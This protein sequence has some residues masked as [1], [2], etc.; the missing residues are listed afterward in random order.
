MSNRP[1]KVPKRSTGNTAPAAATRIGIKPLSNRM[2][3]RKY[4]TVKIPVWPN[5]T[6]TK[7]KG[8][9][10]AEKNYNKL[11]GKYRDTNSNSNSNNSNNNSNN[12][13]YGVPK[14]LVEAGKILQPK[15]TPGLLAVDIRSLTDKL[16]NMKI[17][18]YKGVLYY[19]STTRNLNKIKTEQNNVKA[20]INAANKTNS[21]PTV[22]DFP[23][24]SKIRVL[25]G[26]KPIGS[27]VDWRTDDTKKYVKSENL[28]TRANL[29]Y[30][31]GKIA[32]YVTKPI[33]DFILRVRQFSMAIEYSGFINYD[34]NHQVACKENS[35]SA[36]GFPGEAMSCELLPYAMPN[37]ITFHSHPWHSDSP[38]L[39]VNG[40]IKPNVHTFPSKQD[41]VAYRVISWYG[42][43]CKL[44]II[45][46]L[47]G[48]W[49]IDNVLPIQTAGN[50]AALAPGVNK[51][52]DFIFNDFVAQLDMSS[53]INKFVEKSGWYIECDTDIYTKNVNEYFSRPP[54]IDMLGCNVRFY[55]YSYLDNAIKTSSN[56]VS[57]LPANPISIFNV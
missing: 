30:Y 4:P 21:T 40:T 9:N 20:I 25:I 13:T 15:N 24:E 41:F 49:I 46:D 3:N 35:S 34:V 51:G 36:T 27:E 29:K 37:H 18:S 44:N 16:T 14:G 26:E 43:K 33:L 28:K 47:N 57:G 39:T 12:N 5:I 54:V 45:I 7:P 52:V 19:E 11:F 55:P 56:S 53:S 48:M 50:G 2:I 22:E 17:N 23:G 42:G 32:F 31:D 10:V 38:R 6:V 8:L 1:A